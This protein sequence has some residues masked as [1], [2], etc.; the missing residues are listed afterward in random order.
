LQPDAS[1]EAIRRYSQHY[2]DLIDLEENAFKTLPIHEVL[3]PAYPTLRYMVQLEQDGFFTTPRMRVSREDLPRLAI[4]FQS[5]L[6]RTSFADLMQR[7]LR[8]VEQH[9]HTAVDMEITLSIPNP[10]ELQ[11]RVEISLLQCRPQSHLRDVHAVQLPRD[12]ADE[13][14][15]FMTD[16]MVPQGYLPGIRYVVFVNPEGYYRLPTQAARTE[17]STL[18]SKLNEVLGEK[19]FICVGPGRWGSTNTDLGVF[20]SYADIHNAGALVE[21]SGEGVGPAPEPSLGT[22]FFQDLM[23]AQIYPL[24][25]N[26]DQDGTIFNRDFF[27]NAPTHLGEFFKLDDSFEDALHLIDVDAFRPGHHLEIIMDDEARKAVAFLTSKR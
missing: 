3:T 8:T 17:L 25:L 18:I 22:H 20:V 1:T 19:T 21:L 13:D 27:Y 16:F 23:E 9:Y 4:T 24:A 14:I 5:L 2:V 10:R 12:L 11:P 7:I 26:L 15:V 6:Q